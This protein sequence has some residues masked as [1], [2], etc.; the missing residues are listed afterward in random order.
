M[1]IDERIVI[2]IDGSNFYHGLKYNYKKARINFE[3]LS[4]KLSDGRR[5]IRTYYY[6]V[7]I[8]Q[9]DNPNRY[10]EQQRFFSSLDLVPYFETT[11]GRLVKRERTTRCG[12]CGYQERIIFHNEKGIDVNIA[13]DMLTMAFKN[14]YDTAILI[15][16]DGD[17]DKAIKGVKDLGKHVENAYFKSG[18]SKQLMK[19]CDRFIELDGDF[20]IDCWS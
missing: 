6:N 18:H 3:K 2:F 1:S 9:K 4:A 14:I 5:H 7:P 13:V 15:S 17:F 11:L 10:K 19:I 8:D 16:G 20:L 12:K